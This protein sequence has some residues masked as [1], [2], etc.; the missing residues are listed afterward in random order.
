MER[1]STELAHATKAAA[2]AVTGLNSMLGEMR[3]KKDRGM[4]YP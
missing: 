3:I 1:A 2:A 4:T